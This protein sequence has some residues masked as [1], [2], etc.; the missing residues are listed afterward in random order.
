VLTAYHVAAGGEKVNENR[1]SCSTSAKARRAPTSTDLNP[2]PDF[3]G[4]PSG[5][6]GPL[7]AQQRR[8]QPLVR[9]QS[10]ERNGWEDWA[11]LELDNASAPRRTPMV[12]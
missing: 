10:V 11:L 5:L 7:C 9:A 8:Q 2:F 6:V 12:I 3:L 4:R 1:A